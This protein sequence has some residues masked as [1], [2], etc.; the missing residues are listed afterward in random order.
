MNLIVFGIKPMMV[1]SA[2]NCVAVMLKFAPSETVTA[3]IRLD[4]AWS[5]S[6]LL[7]KF[8]AVSL[9]VIEVKWVLAARLVTSEANTP[10]T[11]NP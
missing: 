2:V 8:A 7:A 9:T 1:E 5:V 4:F 6:I 3:V 10:V 11:I